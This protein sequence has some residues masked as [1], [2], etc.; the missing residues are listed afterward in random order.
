ML[1]K[2]GLP[3]RI[4][5]AIPVHVYEPATH[6]RIHLDMIQNAPEPLPEVQWNQL[7]L[8]FYALRNTGSEPHTT[9]VL[10][11]YRNSGL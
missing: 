1:R 3:L 5:E 2:P 11:N 6:E 8:G 9:G 4:F 7:N 10:A